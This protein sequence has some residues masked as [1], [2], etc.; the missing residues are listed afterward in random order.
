MSELNILSEEFRTLVE[1]NIDR[2]P[3]EIA[4]DSRVQT[5]SA[6]AT[7]VKYLQRAQRKLPSYFA[8][9]CVIPPRAFEQSSSEASALRKE[10]SGRVAL[11][12]T[13]GLGVDSWA[14]SRG[15]KQVIALERDEELAAIA[16]ENFR[17]LGVDNIQVINASAK[18]FLHTSGLQFDLVYADPDRRG[19]DGQKLVRMEDCSPDIVELLPVIQSI[20]PHLVV[21]LSPLFDVDEVFRI[22]SPSGSTHATSVEVVSLDGECKEVLVDIQF[23]GDSKRLIK[24]IAIDLCEV[25]YVFDEHL[26]ETTYNFSKQLSRLDQFNWLVIPDVALQK[27][28]LA[29]RH[30]SERGICIDS[31][32]G[33]GFAIER[34][35]N[36]LGKIFEIQSIEPFDPKTLKRRLKAEKIKNVDILKRNFPL[37]AAEIARQIGV[38]EGG[39]TRIAF[40]QMGGKLWQIHL[41]NL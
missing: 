26:A 27:A 18:D 14:L 40:T 10:F 15:F 28:R 30:L 16:R 34:P 32:N 21:K 24:A 12:L 39:K 23:S 29:K 20:T 17:R 2:N 38:C 9:K 25:T 37:S 36:I 22:F 4:L 11:D 8:T 6:V 19:A 5:A 1:A 33:Y 3:L 41:R 7:Q 13:C 31:D 35:E